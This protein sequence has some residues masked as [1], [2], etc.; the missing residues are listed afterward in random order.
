MSHQN[1]NPY[2]LLRRMLRQ[3]MEDHI[4][5]RNGPWRHEAS[6]NFNQFRME[7]ETNMR[8]RRVHMEDPRPYAGRVLLTRLENAAGAAG[9]ELYGAYFGLCDYIPGRDMMPW[10]HSEPFVLVRTGRMSP[11]LVSTEAV[12]LQCG[13]LP[14]FCRQMPKMDLR[15]VFRNALTPDSFL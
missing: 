2:T 8:C 13:E 9:C 1:N 12:L 15:D 5:P 14:F 7:S 6:R 3:R 4:K 11:L 10:M